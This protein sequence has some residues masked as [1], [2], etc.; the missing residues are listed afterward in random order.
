MANLSDVAKAAGVSIS[1]ASFVLNGR[2]AEMRISSQTAAGVLAAAK[3]LGYVPNV[4]AKKLSGSADPR[5]ALPD[6]S[7]LWSPRTHNSVLGSF[8]MNAQSLFD[9]G[10]VPRM[11]IIIAP[12]PPGH[13][14]EAGERFFN[15]HYNGV[16]IS[17]MFDEEIAFI[18]GLNLQIPMIVL[19]TLVR[20][21]PNVVVDNLAAGHLAARIFAAR[22]H[23][24]AA[25]L[26]RG[27]FGETSQADERITGFRDACETLGLGCRAEEVPWG[28]FRTSADRSDYG[29]QIALR[30]LETKTLPEAMF[31][32]DDTVALGFLVALL[33][34]GVRVPED[35][36]LITYGNEDLAI[37]VSPTITTINYP[38]EGI[39]LEALRL[40][41]KLL[42]DPRVEPVRVMVQPDVTF[43][44]S[45]PRPANWEEN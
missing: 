29:R 10:T 31:I 27:S 28:S 20:R 16:L 14:R 39:T 7:F 13:Y 45:C 42:G 24:G 19:H 43:R 38:I 40:M 35:I 8:I 36:E 21:H 15:R 4:A 34:S 22:G 18:D 30:L 33:R 12:F 1:T 17:P 6:I 11:N 44:D 32:Q 3:A 2:A 26:Y 25:M 9:Q 23:G 41:G 5:T 37:A